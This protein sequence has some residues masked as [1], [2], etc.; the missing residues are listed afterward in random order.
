[1]RSAIPQ[2]LINEHRLPDLCWPYLIDIY[3]VVEFCIAMMGS[4]N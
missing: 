1:M 3:D 4:D 2:V